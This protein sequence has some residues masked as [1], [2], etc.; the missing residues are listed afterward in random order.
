[1]FVVTEFYSTIGN[2]HLMKMFLK[3]K[4]YLVFAKSGNARKDSRFV[5]T[6]LIRFVFLMILE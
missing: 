2:L 1:M 6:L 3:K 4:D 5:V